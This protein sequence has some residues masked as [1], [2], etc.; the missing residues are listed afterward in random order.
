MDSS[1]P[2]YLKGNPFTIITD[3]IDG[4]EVRLGT[5][6]SMTVTTYLTKNRKIYFDLPSHVITQ[7]NHYLQ[8]LDIEGRLYASRTHLD[9][10]AHTR[11]PRRRLKHISTVRSE[12]ALNSSERTCAR[13]VSSNVQ[14]YVV[15][16]KAINEPTGV[17]ATAMIRFSISD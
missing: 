17:I 6:I 14:L 4:K 9:I 1:Y 16:L 13:P 15:G 7:L 5:P 8:L 12:P 2:I 3:T 11:I 10:T